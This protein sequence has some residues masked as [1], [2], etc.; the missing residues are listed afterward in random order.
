VQ[1]TRGWDEKKETTF[2]QRLKEDSHD[3]RYFPDPDLP[4]LKIS[5]VG[6]FMEEKLRA[7]IP[8]LPWIKRDRLIKDFG[9]KEEDAEMFVRSLEWGT[10]FESVIGTFKNDKKMILLASNY[11]T[12]DLAGLVKNNPA[13][14][15]AGVANGGAPKPT[16]FSKLISMVSSNKISSRGA[17]DTLKIMYEKGGN[18][19]TIAKTNNLMQKSDEGELKVI[20]QK[21][22]DAN[23]N[24]AADY[25]AGKAS[26]LQFLIGQGMKETKGSANPEVLKKLFTELL[27]G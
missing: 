15:V 14:W 16:D 6:D 3:Y 18:P 13:A 8:E 19:E 20:V 2:S 27:L 7:E 26:A 21:I 24:V 25:K 17:K 12:S 10:Y 4:K 1:E 11:I 9:I 22:I 23:K 5:E